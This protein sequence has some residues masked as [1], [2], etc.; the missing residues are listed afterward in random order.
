MQA[1]RSPDSVCLPL[2][3][4][5]LCPG[6]RCSVGQTLLGKECQVLTFSVWCPNSHRRPTVASL[7][8]RLAGCLVVALLLSVQGSA[9][10]A[11]SSGS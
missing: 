10:L 11:G 7:D 5:S 3:V 8:Q 2:S 1:V 6:N 4:T 9:G